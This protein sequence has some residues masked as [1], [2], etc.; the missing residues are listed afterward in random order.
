V[1]CRQNSI[2]QRS[3]AGSARRTKKQR[4][5]SGQITATRARHYASKLLQMETCKMLG[6]PEPHCGSA[7]S[8]NK[9]I[10]ERKILRIWLRAGTKNRLSRAARKGLKYLFVCFYAAEPVRTGPRVSGD[11]HS[12]HSQSR[13]SQI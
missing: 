1:F 6:F 12:R 8:I 2:T 13:F 10:H 7:E 5:C 4:E 3:G 9:I 11:T